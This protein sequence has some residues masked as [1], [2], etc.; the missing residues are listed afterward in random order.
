VC[1]AYEVRGVSCYNAVDFMQVALCWQK[2]AEL[3]AAVERVEQEKTNLVLPANQLAQLEAYGEQ[4]V[5]LGI[6]QT[7]LD[8][9]KT[10]TV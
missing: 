10:S 9:P 5:L 6:F 3:K 7:Q 8:V 4:K 1:T 2:V